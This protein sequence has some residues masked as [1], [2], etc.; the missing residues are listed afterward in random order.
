MCFMLLIISC[1]ICLNSLFSTAF[2]LSIPSFFVFVLSKINIELLQYLFVSHEIN[3][4]M[5]IKR[6]RSVTKQY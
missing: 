4:E 6:T 5:F 1:I 2:C 3:I